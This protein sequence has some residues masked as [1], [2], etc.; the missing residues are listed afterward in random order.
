MRIGT[1]PDQ[2]KTLGVIYQT[3]QHELK[4]HLIILDDGVWDISKRMA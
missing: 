4:F 3:N 2:E 1:D